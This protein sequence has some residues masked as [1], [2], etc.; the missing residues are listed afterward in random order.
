[1]ATLDFYAKWDVSL[2]LLRKLKIL[3]R[4]AVLPFAGG[5]FSWKKLYYAKTMSKQKGY[6]KKKDSKFPLEFEINHH[7]LCKNA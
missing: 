5:A 2:M 1:M 4:Y 3:L 6:G 7:W